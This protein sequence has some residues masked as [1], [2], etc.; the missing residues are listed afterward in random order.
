MKLTRAGEY[1]V[2]CVMYLASQGQGTLVSR[3]EVAEFFE[4]PDSFLAKIAQKLAKVGI[5]EIKQGA[6]GGYV[7]RRDP[8]SITMLEVVE[9]I[10]GEIALND[11]VISADTCHSSVNCAVNRVWTRARNQLRATLAEVTFADL[12][13]EDSCFIFPQP[14][15][16]DIPNS[17][18]G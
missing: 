11:C 17:S 9:S 8:V 12:L 6:K 16:V 7:L 1:A 15:Q 14:Q 5:I 13:K 2:R 10:I 4:I 3:R 18:D